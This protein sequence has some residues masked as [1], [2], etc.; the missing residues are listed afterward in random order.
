MT[1]TT[2]QKLMAQI[3]MTKDTLRDGD[4]LDARINQIL[5]NQLAIMDAICNVFKPLPV[6]KFTVPDG[7]RV[8][9]MADI[10]PG[11]YPPVAEVVAIVSPVKSLPTV[12]SPIKEPFL[13]VSAVT[14]FNDTTPAPPAF[15]QPPTPNTPALPVQDIK[16]NDETPL[17]TIL[18]R[19]LRK[20]ERFKGTRC[21][22]SY[23]YQAPFKNRPP[24]CLGGKGCDFCWNTFLLRHFPTITKE[25][26][27]QLTQPQQGQ[28]NGTNN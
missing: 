28:A 2:P 20:F 27:L 24:T 17:P 22:Y 13:Q 18:P 1:S 9:T 15:L 19:A 14:S 25:Q 4:D 3:A 5:H 21:G 8:L 16:L 6:K 26:Y 23:R 10:N 12:E 7:G 11:K